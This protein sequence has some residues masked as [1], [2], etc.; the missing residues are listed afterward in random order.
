MRGKAKV[1]S[2][3][4]VSEMDI[5]SYTDVMDIGKKRHRSKD[6]MAEKPRLPLNDL[7]LE[8]VGDNATRSAAGSALR[9]A[10]LETP[11]SVNLEE[12]SSEEGDDDPFAKRPPPVPPPEDFVDW[13]SNGRWA[14]I[15]AVCDLLD[16]DES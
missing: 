10:A 5:P 9:S 3:E 1:D 2:S 8:D 16:E 4:C 6:Q 12:S 11:T 14:D 13:A 7:S 15:P